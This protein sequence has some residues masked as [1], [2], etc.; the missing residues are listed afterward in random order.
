[1]AIAFDAATDGGFAADLTFAHTC[2]GSDGILFVM[3]SCNDGATITSV[4]YAGAAMTQVGSVTTSGVRD[5][6]LYMKV[7]PATGSNNVVIDV[8]T[9]NVFGG[10]VS[11]TGASQTG[12]PDSFAT[13]SGASVTSI[14]G[15]TT[16]VASNCWLVALGQCDSGGANVSGGSG[17]TER[18]RYGGFNQFGMFD[19]NGTVGT[20]SQSLIVNSNTGVDAMQIIVASFAPPGGGGGSTV[21]PSLGLLGVGA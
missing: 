19:S 9:G 10:A 4:T 2:T 7:G 8:S 17:T 20:G 5:H 6:Y 3:F 13:N 16:V 21:I 1:M 11:Y 12:Q 14:T 18:S 15:T